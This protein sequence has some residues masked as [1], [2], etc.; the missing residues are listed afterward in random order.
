[1]EV[2]ASFLKPD[3]TVTY[4][5]LNQASNKNKLLISNSAN[6]TEMQVF[7]LKKLGLH[8]TTPECFLSH[9]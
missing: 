1:M 3:Y 2:Q 7:Y 5:T 4:S 8:V 6:A 9:I